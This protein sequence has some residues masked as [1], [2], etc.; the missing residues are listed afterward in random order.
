VLVPDGKGGRLEVAVLG[1]GQFVGERSVINDKLR[2]ADCVAQGRVQ[3]RVQMPS[4]LRLHAS[5]CRITGSL[6]CMWRVPDH[7]GAVGSAPRLDVVLS[8][9]RGNDPVS[10][11][12]CARTPVLVHPFTRSSCVLM[13]WCAVCKQV[14]VLRKRDFLDLD[15]PLL[16]WML[17]YDAVSAVLKSLPA[18]KGLKQDQM[19]HIFDRFEA[20][21]E[22]YKGDTIISQ[23]ALVSNPAGI[24]ARLLQ[25]VLCA[26]CGEVEMCGRSCTRETPSSRRARW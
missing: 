24:G 25:G 18:F 4:S 23:G 21:Q 14:V 22:L 3:V 16:A 1:R 17:D 12:A 7:A 19:E 11:R 9:L 6:V 5:P 10:L 13:C 20:R 2:S 8:A 15:N 26:V